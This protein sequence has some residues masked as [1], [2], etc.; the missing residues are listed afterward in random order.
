MG[1]YPL[2]INGL[3]HNYGVK[4]VISDVNLDLR[5]GECL[6]VIGS[7]GCGKTTILRAV[8]GFLKASAGSINIKGQTV[9][10]SGSINKRN[11]FLAPEKRK[12]GYVCQDFALF[13]HLTVA[14]NIAFG[15]KARK[16]EK[17]ALKK[18]V[19][20]LLSLIQMSAEAKRLP[21]EL[22]GGQQQ[23]VALA[24]ALAIK[25][26]VLLLDEPFAN[27]DAITRM[28]LSEQLQQMVQQ[29]GVS[30][31]L[32][33]HDRLE[34]FALADRLA[35]M[36][37]SKDNTGS[38]MVQCAAPKVVYDEPINKEVAELLGPCA[39]LPVQANGSSASSAL[40]TLCLRGN[41]YNQG[42][43]M[44]RPESVLFKPS[45]DGAYRVISRAFQGR[46]Y[47]LLCSNNE[48][49]F[50]ADSTVLNNVELG[51]LGSLEVK[52]PVMFYSN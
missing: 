21:G 22:S 4:K 6:A 2:S 19:D 36:I 49:K 20:E 42:E 39:W 32:V 28:E 44:L 10:H 16:W 41:F 37:S 43:V 11:I 35:I 9:F 46:H 8:A 30:V 48:H 29:E 50:W 1:D 52:T 45:S 18:R 40:G 14:E 17:S 47:R 12:L 3:S 7:S 51:A 38:K 13:P 34:A 24:R 26:S 25:P 33:T 23:R 31:L 5:Q 15:L 27:I